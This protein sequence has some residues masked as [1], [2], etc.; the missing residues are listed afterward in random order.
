[1]S[2]ANYHTTKFFSENL[3]AI[4]MK[5]TQ[6][7]MNMLVYLGL[8]LLELSKIVLYEFWYDYLKTKYKD[9]AKLCYMDTGNFIAYII[10][11]DIYADN[12][13]DVEARFDT[14]NYELGKSL[15]K[16]NNKKVNG[17][18][19]DE[20]GGKITK[21]LAALRVKTYSYLTDERN[22]V[23]KVKG[24]KKCVIKKKLK[25]KLKLKIMK[26]V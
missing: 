21:E 14:P 24:T 20:I 26:T 3:L 6:I 16:G 9:K 11:K 22:G 2:E 25:L 1:M 10:T 13:K 7:I 19:K 4:E 17:L 23:K 15:P 18:M 5:K 12:A 8:S